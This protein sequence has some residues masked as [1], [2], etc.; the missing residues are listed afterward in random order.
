[1]NRSF[2]Q[3]HICLYMQSYNKLSTYKLQNSII[4]LYQKWLDGCGDIASN[5]SYLK[6]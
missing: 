2:T 1:M 4:V 5:S 3:V 6:G